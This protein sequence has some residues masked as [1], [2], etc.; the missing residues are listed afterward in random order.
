[1]QLAAIGDYEVTFQMTDAT[2]ATQ[3]ELTLNGAPIA[4]SVVGRA[5]GTSQLVL[6]TII[7]TATPNS[8]L[9]VLN[10]A[11]NSNS[12]VQ[13]P[14]DGSETQQDT[15]SLRIIRLA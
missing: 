15:M 4:T 1:V 7:R 11:G 9:Q 3:V 2:G 6:S 14:P 10:P 5:T 13:P 12:L 8:T